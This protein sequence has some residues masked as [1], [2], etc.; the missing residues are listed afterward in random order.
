MR[1]VRLVLAITLLI[2]A[3]H[4]A[5]QD[6]AQVPPPAPAAAATPP[7]AS[8]PDDVDPRAREDTDD[9]KKSTLD[10]CYDDWRCPDPLAGEGSITAADYSIHAP[11]Y[12]PPAFKS[13][14]TIRRCVKQ[15]GGKNKCFTLIRRQVRMARGFTPKPGAAP[16]QVQLQ[17]PAQLLKV[18][19]RTL[20][21]EDRL[22]CGGSLIAWGWVVTAAHCI[23]DLGANIKDAGYRIRLGVS[24]IQA[25]VEGASYKIVDA[26]VSPKYDDKGYFS[27]IALIHFAADEQTDRSKRAWVQLITV[28]PQPPWFDRG[29]GS[30]AYFYGWGQTEAKRPSAMLQMGVVALQPSAR[31]ARSTIALCASGVG[32]N[33]AA[34]CHGDSGGPLVVFE[35]K[36]PT[37][38]GIVSHNVG[39][40]ECGSN[41][42]PGVFTRIAPF[43]TWIEQH[44]GPLPKPRPAANAP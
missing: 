11:D 39:K 1:A 29:A 16:W 7:S 41:K 24:N 10:P 28:D 26:V 19:R 4:L 40:V 12:R 33:W 3:H 43:K 22:E 6:V 27:D 23:D 44:T 14:V 13:S 9:G 34:Q 17:R 37:L 8:D 30:H 42:A 25:G 18:T 2:G 21:W 35:N 36:V 5:A 20:D 32:S 38:I 31:C 15:R